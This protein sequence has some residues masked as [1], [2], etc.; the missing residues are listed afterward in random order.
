[1]KKERRVQRVHARKGIRR[2]EKKNIQG[3]EE[4]EYKIER[5]RQRGRE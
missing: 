1:M 3:E 5:K 4:I 2:T